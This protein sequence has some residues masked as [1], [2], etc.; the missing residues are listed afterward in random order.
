MATVKSNWITNLTATPVVLTNAAKS[1]GVLK[2]ALGVATTLAAQ[3]DNDIVLMCRVP[4]NARIS[5]VLFSSADAT[6]GG[7]IDVG[8]YETSENGGAVVDRD[9]FAS[10]YVL[11]SGPHHNLDL[12]YESTE[13]TYAESGTP[14]WEVLG[15]S[16][17]PC[18]DYD[19]ALTVETVFDGGP[20]TCVLKV[21]YVI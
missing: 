17:D 19:I 21:R 10:A 4:S 13:Y 18:K 14:L 2:E 7:A 6:T 5:E 3:A 8:V 15:L 11:T 12:T 9:L 16:S 20:T 1:V